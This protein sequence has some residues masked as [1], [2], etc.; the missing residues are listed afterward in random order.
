MCFHRVTY[1]CKKTAKR[2]VTEWVVRWSPHKMKRSSLIFKQKD[3]QW[4]FRVQE[5]AMLKEERDLGVFFFCGVSV[6][7]GRFPA[8]SLTIEY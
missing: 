8:S 5:H 6:S 4:S 2:K 1:P 7:E 3:E